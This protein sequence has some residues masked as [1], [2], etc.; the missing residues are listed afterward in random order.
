M[1]SNSKSTLL[2]TNDDGVT[3]P[4]LIP[5]IDALKGLGT[6][7]RV[8]TLVPDRERSWIAKSISRFDEIEVRER[9][10][11]GNE[12]RIMTASGTPADCTNL[13]VYRVFDGK[14]DL[15]VSG[16]NIGL[17]HGLG[18]MMSSGTVGAAAEGAVAGLPAIAISIGAVGDG[19]GSFVDYALS[20]AGAELWERSAAVSAD[21][22]ASVLEH[23]IPGGVDLLNVNLPKDATLETPRVVTDVARVGYNALFSSEDS[24]RYVFDYRGLNELKSSEVST[25][26]SALR[27]GMISITPLQ[28]PHAAPFEGALHDALTKRPARTSARPS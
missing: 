3:S 16:V 19:H 12:P 10:R 18:F 20:D 6:V 1:T 11:S 28:L 24:S 26:S 15:V 9:E 21:I 22:V 8:N 23:G 25:D 17:N 13:G 5:L 7:A 14:P 4:A 2:V 27:E